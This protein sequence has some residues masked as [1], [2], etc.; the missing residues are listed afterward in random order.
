[1]GTSEPVPEELL[2]SA[3]S[4]TGTHETGFVWGFLFHPKPKAE[5]L[6]D[7]DWRIVDSLGNKL[8]GFEAYSIRFKVPTNN[9][10][11]L[12]LR[13]FDRYSRRELFGA[14]LF[15]VLQSKSS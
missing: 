1:M 12:G 6:E 10:E 9:G 5:F 8:V 2:E 11:A 15:C 4:L 7:F 3:K 14:N 13:F